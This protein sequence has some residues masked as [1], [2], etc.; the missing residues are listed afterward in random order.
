MIRLV[1]RASQLFLGVALAQAQT[2]DLARIKTAVEE[3]LARLPN[4]TCTES[5]EQSDRLLIDGKPKVVFLEKTRLE[6]AFVEGKE[7]FGWPGAAKIDQ[8]DVTRMIK[9]SIGN[10]YFGLFSKTI[11][12]APSTTFQNANTTELDGRPVVRYDYRVPQQTGAY[13]IKT[14]T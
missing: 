9:G 14:G 1:P 2:D 3:N 7:L 13:F 6:V 8:S 5:I 11:F 10:G 12:L 4:Y